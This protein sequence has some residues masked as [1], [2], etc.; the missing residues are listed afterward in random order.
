MHQTLNHLHS[1]HS[2]YLVIFFYTRPLTFIQNFF[3]QLFDFRNHPI[4]YSKHLHN[5]EAIVF[6]PLATIP[7]F[8][9]HFPSFKNLD[10][11]TRVIH[12]FPL[13]YLKVLCPLLLNH[14]GSPFLKIL[15]I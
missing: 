6:I 13:I 15:K 12:A 7:K 2:P 8:T 1:R 4:V 5:R 11:I 9:K 10:L 14:L 3:H